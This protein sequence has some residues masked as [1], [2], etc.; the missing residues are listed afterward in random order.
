MYRR[1]KQVTEENITINQAFQ[2][3]IKEKEALGLSEASL[4]GYEQSITFFI[5]DMVLKDIPFS[6]VDDTYIYQ[7]INELKERGCKTSSINHYLA[8]L[9]AFLKWSFKHNYLSEFE[10]KLVKGQEP[11]PKFFTDDELQILIKK[12]DKNDSFVTWRTYA[13]ICFILATG[14]RAS[15]I[16]NVKISDI[17]FTR[18]EIAYTHLKNKHIA[19]VPLSY[20]LESTLTEYLKMWQRQTN[21]EWLFCDIAEC[22][23]TVSALRQALGKYC[24]DR[25]IV[26]KGPHALRHSFA[27]GWILNNGNAFT[28]QKMLTHSTLTMT[29]RYVSLFGDDLKKDF[30]SFSPLD[31]I[32]KSGKMQLI[33]RG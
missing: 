14:A 21:K 18:K 10:I 6:N 3:F 32:K 23:L 27:R 17:D 16:I 19:V 7:W 20:S 22:Q 1:W 33:R 28:L 4:R 29:K 15:T 31:N 26:S 5:D 25:N 30:E 13:I 11:Q 8:S 9:R 12:P 24:S 2:E